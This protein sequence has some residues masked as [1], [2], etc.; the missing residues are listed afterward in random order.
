LN[1]LSPTEHERTE[2]GGEAREFERRRRRGGGRARRKLGPAIDT[3]LGGAMVRRIGFLLALVAW[4]ELRQVDD[5]N[6][7]IGAG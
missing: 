7:R 5:T 4:F 6:P 3:G 2:A 1:R